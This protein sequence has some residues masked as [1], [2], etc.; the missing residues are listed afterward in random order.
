MS[1]I[2]TDCIKRNKYSDEY[3][4]IVAQITPPCHVIH[5]WYDLDLFLKTFREWNWTEDNL[6]W[7]K[8]AYGQVDDEELET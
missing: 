5:L 1:L 6:E 8:E 7:A 3:T 4:P 2:P